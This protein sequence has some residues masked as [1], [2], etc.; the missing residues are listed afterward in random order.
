MFY[1]DDGDAFAEVLPR[2]LH[3][4]GKIQMATVER[5]NSNTHH[6]LR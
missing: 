3:I 6:H 1:T 5:D 4:V 2:D